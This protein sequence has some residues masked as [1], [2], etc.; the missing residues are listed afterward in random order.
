MGESKR[1][2]RGEEEEDDI[3]EDE[4][5]NQFTKCPNCKVQIK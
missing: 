3:T 1:I 5:E 4:I 2:V